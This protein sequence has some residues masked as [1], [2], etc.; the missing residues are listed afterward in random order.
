[1]TAL[2]LVIS[3][4]L[5]ISFA[6]SIM[7][8]VLLSTTQSFVAVLRERGERAGALLQH[9]RENIDEPIAAILTLNTIG[10]TVGATVAGALAL[11]VFPGKAGIALFSAALTFAILV[12][13]EIIPKTLGARYWRTLAT[14]T[15][16]VLSGLMTVMKP[17]LVP[18]GAISRLLTPKGETGPRMSR[19]EM[20]VHRRYRSP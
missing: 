9:M 18:L 3:A 4:A 11:R 19:A 8:A 10:H 13:S 16:Y 15:A 7:E 5:T 1:M 2:F 17:V 14:P 6:C 20:E 12:F